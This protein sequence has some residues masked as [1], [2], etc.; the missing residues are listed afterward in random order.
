MGGGP[1]GLGR[2]HGVLKG[3]G[4]V[5][6][7]F[8]AY[9]VHAFFSKYN[10]RH[11]SILHV[12]PESSY[13]MSDSNADEL[14]AAITRLREAQ[15]RKALV[16]HSRP[17]QTARQFRDGIRMFRSGML[18]LAR[19]ARTLIIG[20][21]GGG[22]KLLHGKVWAAE[23]AVKP[24]MNYEVEIRMRASQQV[25]RSALCSFEYVGVDGETIAWEERHCNFSQNWGFVRYL[26]AAPDGASC[27]LS[28][29][30]PERAVRLRVH[31]VG[32]WRDGSVKVDFCD[33]A[34]AGLSLEMQRE[35]MMRLIGDP[36]L[37]RNG[38]AIVLPGTRTEDAILRDHAR[39]GT[40]VLNFYSS[41]S[42]RPAAMDR[43]SNFS[44]ELF[45]EQYR[46]VASICAGAKGRYLHIGHADYYTV[47]QA[48]CLKYH[49][50]V[51]SFEPAHTQP[52]SDV[53]W[54]YLEQ[55]AASCAPAHP[56]RVTA[57]G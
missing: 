30:P 24:S 55:L 53:R 16:M 17:V 14:T 6:A 35:E 12:F 18:L 34:V 15:H 46:S 50:W 38:I 3:S 5:K 37:S 29:D 10:A 27:I 8:N 42:Q 52:A 25:A 57:G 28:L 54:K 40:L 26:E 9:S 20:A 23:Y 41:Y 2:S 11:D 36:S 33:V 48:N 44:V 32:W 21:P 31:I 56:D 19:G 7:R 49:G 13:H 39:N 47:L 51:I 4:G 22:D 43:M 45:N 1:V